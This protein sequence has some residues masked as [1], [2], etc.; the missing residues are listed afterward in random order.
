MGRGLRRA[1]LVPRP[2]NPNEVCGWWCCLGRSQPSARPGRQR[3]V[4]AAGV[5]AVG[6]GGGG[7]GGGAFNNIHNTRGRAGRPHK[8]IARNKFY[9]VT[10]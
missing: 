1:P 10:Y 8:I 5:A 3:L 4:A 6:G 9:I 7:E 2:V